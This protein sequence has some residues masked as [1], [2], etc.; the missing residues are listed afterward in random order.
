MGKPRPAHAPLRLLI[1]AGPTREPIDAVRFLSNYSTGYMGARLAE[2]ALRRGH[3]VAMV[4]G[5]VTEPLPGN[6]RVTRV[7]TTDQMA[8]ALTRQAPGADAVIM[9]AA[10]ADYRPARVARAKLSRAGG[11][12][13]RLTATQDVI[14]GLPRRKR[15]VIAGFALETSDAVAKARRKLRAKRLDVI[16]AQQADQANGPFGRRRIRAWLLTKSG[17]AAPLGLASKRVVARAL[18]DKV[19]RLWY[20]QPMATASHDKS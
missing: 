4:T 16:V 18:L 20:G 14:A 12:T 10:V 8:R 6:A 19:E 5:P 13:L 7:E 2:E 11:A 15:Q 9:A 1:S 17:Q 3:R